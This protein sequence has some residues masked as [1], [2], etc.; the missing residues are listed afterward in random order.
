[1]KRLLTSVGALAL[2]SALA[3]G[4]KS[5]E[6]T[7]YPEDLPPPVAETETVIY[8]DIYIE[9]EEVMQASEENPDLVGVETLSNGDRVEVV[10]YVHTYPEAIETFPQV[11]WGGRYYY[12]VHGNFVFYSSYYH[13]WCYYWGPPAP[14][15]YAWNYY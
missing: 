11:Y 1:M 14:L 8:Q 2:V 9:T 6:E 4:C 3:S 13:C 7:L 10:T 5:K 15:V 12:N